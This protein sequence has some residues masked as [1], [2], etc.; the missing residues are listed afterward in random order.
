[1]YHVMI[2]NAIG[3]LPLSRRTSVL[4]ASK[5]VL[6]HGRS[7]VAHRSVILYRNGAP[8]PMKMGN[9][10]SLWRYDGVACYPLQSPNPRQAAMLRYALLGKPLLV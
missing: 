8:R 2:P 6:R 7:S 4:A 1:M 10:L 5:R 9:I 3:F